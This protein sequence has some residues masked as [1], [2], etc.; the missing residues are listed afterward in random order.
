MLQYV[1]SDYLATGEG[2][3]RCI[4]ITMAYPSA[5]DYESSDSHMNPDGSFHFEM[6]KLKENVTPES[7]ALREF[8]K[9][10]G[11]YYAIGAE[12]I[13]EEQ[14]RLKWLKHC[15]AYMLNILDDQH[16]PNKAA[17]NIYYAQKL[18]VNYS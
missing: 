11:P 18:H 7:I 17:G 15:P 5:E 1:V 4:L 14:F 16:D 6:P 12:V 8:K 9:E 3:T 10:F 2:L 13:S